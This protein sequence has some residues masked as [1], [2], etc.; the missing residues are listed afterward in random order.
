MS[1]LNFAW[2]STMQSDAICGK[3]EAIVER[4]SLKEL[5]R[6]AYRSFFQD[7]LVDI[8]LGLMV[9]T[10]A[11]AWLLM[12]RRVS[13]GYVIGHTHITSVALW[14]AAM[15]VLVAGRRYITI[16]RLG[17][18]RFGPAR[19]QRRTRAAT[20]MGAMVGAQAALV[21]LTATGAVDFRGAPA[22]PV[23]VIGLMVLVALGLP[24]Y[25]LDFTRLYAYAVVV[26]GGVVGAETLYMRTASAM[27]AAAIFAAAGAIPVLVG[28]GLLIRF[29]R[30]YPAQREVTS[31]GDGQ[32]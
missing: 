22:T 5:E 4:V 7:G 11:N 24:A 27:G 17:V 21:V 2:Q 31:N 20:V 3:K 9:L 23:M 30:A 32:S 13:W 29:V 10:M 6:K 18:V 8:C 25:L 16:P 19:K 12:A 14:A 15:A 26:A 1:V 28:L